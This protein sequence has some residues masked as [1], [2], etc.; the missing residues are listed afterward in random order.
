MRYK[1]DLFLSLT[2]NFDLRYKIFIILSPLEEG[3]LPGKL[4]IV[5]YMLLKNYGIEDG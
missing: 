4:F 3:F 5:E 2:F 1:I